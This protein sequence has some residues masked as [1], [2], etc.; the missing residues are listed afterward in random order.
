MTGNVDDPLSHGEYTMRLRRLRIRDFR[1]IAVMDTE[2]PRDGMNIAGPNCVGKTNVI[3][4]IRT[5]LTGV[6]VAPDAIRD[7]ADDSEVMVDTDD[8]RMSHIRQRISASGGTLTVSTAEGDRVSRPRER[9]SELCGL[10]CFDPLKFFQ[11]KGQD[12][13]RM[14]LE[15]MPVKVSAEDL[16]RWTGDKWE[17]DE[18]RHGL[19][20]VAE[21]RKHYYDPRTDVNKALK[22]AKAKWETATAEAQR[23][24]DAVPAG[25]VFPV[26]GD[27]EKAAQSAWRALEALNER[28]AQVEAQRKK[29]GATRSRIAEMRSRADEIEANEPP[30]PTVAERLAIDS[31]IADGESR[32]QSLKEQLHIA[33]SLLATARDIMQS[34]VGRQEAAN[35]NIQEVESLRT[36]ASELATSLASVAIEPVSDEQMQSARDAVAKAEKFVALANKNHRAQDALGTACVLGDEM[37]DAQKKAD[38]LD[39]IVTTLT[40]VAP[41]EL[42]SRA[43]LVPGI[44]LTEDGVLYQGR[45]IDDSMSGSQ[46]MMVA[47]QI[48][49]RANAKSGILLVDE[50]GVLDSEHMREFVNLCKA[51]GW[52]LITTCMRNITGP[53]GKL[54]KEMVLEAIELE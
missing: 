41:V 35:K 21:V 15:S 9:L 12:Q 16:L 8:P 5:T 23:L 31:E 36:R 47:V 22:A 33:E 53:D 39:A 18:S 51:D 24:S 46:R 49:K 32:V 37:T 34:Y 40:T 42:A 28:C 7:G 14:I 38:A 30:V 4:A 10:S 43:N 45:P 25:V 44:T 6:G 17:T 26:P 19:D 27:A 52:Q 20:V 1:S 13:R 48:A 54:A 29:E 3:R 50:I 2:I 11:A